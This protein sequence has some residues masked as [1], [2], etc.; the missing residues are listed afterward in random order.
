VSI[1][2][3]PGVALL[4]S[5]RGYTTVRDSEKGGLLFR[6][7]DALSVRCYAEG[8]LA[9]TDEIV[10]S[11]ATGLPLLHEIARKESQRAVRALRDQTLIA[12][13]LLG[14]EGIDVWVMA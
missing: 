9:T 13:S 12:C 7:G 14:I 4:W 3:N 10:H 6:I 2:R 5:T 11:V 8:R 1:D